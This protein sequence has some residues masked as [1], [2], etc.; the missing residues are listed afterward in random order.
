MAEQGFPQMTTTNWFGIAGPT[1]VPEEIVRRLHAEI[2]HALA[3]SAVRD[4]LAGIGVSRRRHARSDPGVRAGR[5][6]ALGPRDQGDRHHR[7]LIGGA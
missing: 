1:G 7:A 6:R 4:R 3:T 5:D 2:G